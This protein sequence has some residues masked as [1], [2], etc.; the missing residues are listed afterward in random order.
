MSI[1]YSDYKKKLKERKLPKFVSVTIGDRPPEVQKMSQYTDTAE[2]NYFTYIKKDGS[3][4]FY[5]IRKEAHEQ[6]NGKKLFYVFYLHSCSSE[7]LVYS[8]HSR[9][10]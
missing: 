10:L 1:D 8:I 6:K 5:V 9:P 7:D 3:V 4:A 2:N